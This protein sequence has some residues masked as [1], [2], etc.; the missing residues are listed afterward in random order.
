M[1]DVGSFSSQTLSVRDSTIP[2]ANQPH[3]RNEAVNMDDGELKNESEKMNL[4]N[5]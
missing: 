4:K 1:I 2:I 5:S 3:F